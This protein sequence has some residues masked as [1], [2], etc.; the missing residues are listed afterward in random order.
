[1]ARAEASREHE[2][3]AGAVVR[4]APPWT[5]SVVALVAL[6]V[7]A[8]I[9][10]AWLAHIE[11]TDRARGITRPAGGVRPLFA[12]SDAVVAEVF[13]QSGQRVA[14]N[15]PIARLR[16]ADTEATLVEVEREIVRASRDRDSIL[17]DTQ[18][19]RQRA[20]LLSRID[21]MQQ[22]RATLRDSASHRQRRL[23]AMLE[24]ERSGLVSAIQAGDER[25]EALQSTRAQQAA[26]EALARTRQELAA[27]D[28]ARAR[29]LRA[30]ERALQEAAARRDALSLPLQRG[31]IA[32]PDGGVVE[33]LLTRP[34]D[35]VRA[36]QL[37]ARLVSD[38]AA[39][40]IVAFVPEKHRASIRA[41][42]RAAVELDQFPSLEFGALPARV[43]RVAGDLASRQEV[44]EAMGDGV[45]I[46]GARVRVELELLP[47][48]HLERVRTGMLLDV[49]L[50]LRRQRL[51]A[52]LLEPL[53]PRSGT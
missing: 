44:A 34:G 29:D 9:G 40:R 48:P 46:E 43:V 11:V 7:V 1:M 23:D 4:M 10:F 52:A 22:Q 24:L 45:A 30:A 39:P 36:G 6:L 3:D 14:A 5:W 8:A 53:A 32:A 31:L 28:A 27:L 49:R 35:Y 17:G 18:F 15:A 12:Q 19:E 38:D 33:A 20:E 25:E 13:V 47:S 21:S 16:S 41:G 37:I 42:D 51:L 50:T 2:A 26:G